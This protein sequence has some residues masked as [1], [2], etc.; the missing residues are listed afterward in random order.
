MRNYINEP[1]ECFKIKDFLLAHDGNEA[2]TTDIPARDGSSGCPSSD[3]A[4]RL[5]RLQ[6]QTH[7]GDLAGLAKMKKQSH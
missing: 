1:T 3:L 5:P 2:T 6:K 4:R 7:C